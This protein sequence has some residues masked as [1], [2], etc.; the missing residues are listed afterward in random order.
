MQFNIRSALTTE[1]GRGNQKTKKNT[2]KKRSLPVRD[3]WDFEDL[4]LVSPFF[5]LLFFFFAFRTLVARGLFACYPTRV[6]RVEIGLSE[7]AAPAQACH[8]AIIQ[9]TLYKYCGIAIHVAYNIFMRK[10]RYPTPSPSPLLSSCVVQRTLVGSA[11]IFPG[12]PPDPP[13][14]SRF[15]NVNPPSPPFP[16]PTRAPAPL[17]TPRSGVCLVLVDS[18]DRPSNGPVHS[19]I[20]RTAIYR[21]LHDCRRTSARRCLFAK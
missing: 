9:W 14:N 17:L 12:V 20:R 15:S 4:V 19:L 21:P 7:R 11:S 2:Q 1:E 5:V 13:I 3:Y 18:S 8:G 6:S 16:E 10:P